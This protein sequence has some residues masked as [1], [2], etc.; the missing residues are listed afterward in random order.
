VST[1]DQILSARIDATAMRLARVRDWTAEH[2][3]AAS[4]ELR[5]LADGQIDLLTAEAGLALGFGEGSLTPGDTGGWP[6]CL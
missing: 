3:A 5:K 6:S 1:D 4:A 2:K